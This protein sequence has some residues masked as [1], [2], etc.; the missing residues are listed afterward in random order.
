MKK[1]LEYIKINEKIIEKIATEG[2]E[3]IEKTAQ[4][5]SDALMYNRKIF[6]FIDNYFI[7]LGKH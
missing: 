3:N 5:F 6:L 2:A 7:E 4:L 1:Y